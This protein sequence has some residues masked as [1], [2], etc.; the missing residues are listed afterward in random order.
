VNPRII[1]SSVTGFGTA[2]PQASEPG[3]DPLLQ[4]LSG[5]MA[6]QGGDDEP[7]FHQIAVN[8]NLS[9]MMAA[10]GA[11]VALY[12]RE[13]T[14]RGQEV[15]TSLANQATFFQ[16]GELTWYEGRPPSPKGSLDCV[17]ISAAQR[18]YECVDGEWLALGCTE[19]GHWEAL[20]RALPSA[21]PDGG[22]R[23]LV[24]RE[25]ARRDDTRPSPTR[26][27]R[28]GVVAARLA[29]AFKHIG[30]DEAVERLRAEGVPAAPAVRAED[31]FDDEYLREN[32]VFD[33]YF[34]PQ[35]GDVTGVAGYAGLADEVAGLE[36]PGP[37]FGEHTVEVLREY[38]LDEVRVG[39]LLASGAAK[40]AEPQLL[41]V[42]AE[43]A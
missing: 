37:L 13:H 23:E 34:H 7:V 12:A 32:G 42:L 8:D 35:F 43:P 29:A 3:F 1:T 31:V 10:F 28:D 33:T 41:P 26:F 2:G 9:A 17:G 16:S 15:Q 39:R 21:V 14:G 4:A 25:A 22:L 11:L 6:A 30:R 24:G 38:G 5:L 20:A 40:Q 19:A 27:G 36:R 18:L